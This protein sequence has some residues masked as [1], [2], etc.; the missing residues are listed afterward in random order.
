MRL[1]VLINAYN[2]ANRIDKCISSVHEYVDEIWLYDGAYRQYPNKLPYSTD[3]MIEKASKYSK[4]KIF[5]NN[6][7]LWPDQITKRTA[8]FENGKDGDYFLVLDGDEYV[9][10][11]ENIKKYLTHDVGWVWT[12]SNLYKSPYMKARI[13][14]WHAGMHYAGRHHWL[15]DEKNHFITSDQKMNMK[16]SHRDTPIRIVNY[17]DSSK[18]E[19]I[20][21]K[22]EFI[23]NRSKD[24][25]KYRD[26]LQVYHKSDDRIIPHPKRAG[27]ATNHIK[28]LRY[29]DDIKYT[30]T[31]M[32][33]RPWAVDRYFKHLDK[34]TLPPKTEI[35]CVIDTDDME[36]ANKVI[37]KL[38]KT[39]FDCIKYSITHNEKLP[40]FKGVAYRR[41]RIIDNWHILLSE[42]QGEIILGSEDDSLPETTAYIK[43]L[44]DLVNNNCDF[45][46][47]NI[48]GRWQANM[49]P[50]WHVFED[51]D[52][53][54]I[55]VISGEKKTGVEK[56][57][58]C[59]WYCFVC[60]TDV[61]L[62][63]PMI[64]N[65]SLPLGPDVNFGYTLS[66]NGFTL[67]H[68]WDV[69]VEHFGETFS[70]HPKKDKA[71]VFTWFKNYQNWSIKQSY[72][73]TPTWRK[74]K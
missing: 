29:S 27:T 32:F 33:S 26:E 31:L 4:V 57:Q 39:K 51:R 12:I 8:M 24:E 28:T 59:G 17:R 56:I 60:K 16:Y 11:P 66:R 64:Q 3:G 19:R 48:I 44:D 25:L 49:Y 6:R 20:K 58:G 36:F 72:S 68:D 61:M 47:G 52:G 50:A 42:A 41:Q 14:K 23:A 46:Q 55:K 45:V 38:S 34:L 67:L 43:L 10:N 21:A 69:D 62:K 22:R 74:N 73:L 18:P 30:F 54:P 2:E 40:E 65:D 70:L 1:I 15:Y 37:D 53:K 71:K 5:D 7:E 13:F 63:Y 9:T 35:I